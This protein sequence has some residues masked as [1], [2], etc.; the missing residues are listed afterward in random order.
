MYAVVTT[1]GKQYRVE[2]GSML[3]VEK[4]VAEPGSSVTLD[5]V[6]LVGD[7]DNVTVGTPTV[8]G[9]SVSATVLGEERGQKIVV[10]KFKQK[11][12]YRRRT[13]HRQHLTRLRVDSI[14]AGGKTERAAEPEKPVVTAER[15]TQPSAGAKKPRRTTRARGKAE[16]S[17][18]EAPAEKPKADVEQVAQA[19][20]ATPKRRARAKAPAADEAQDK[21]S[22]SEGAAEASAKQPKPRGRRTAKP[23]D[24]SAKEE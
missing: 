19:A 6:L 1:G 11:V 7:G 12:K 18:P 13:G 5:R 20:E 22:A 24:G 8:S 9:A 15:A 2:A 3:L 16:S 21:T 17:V 10:F 4:I 14:T 23:K